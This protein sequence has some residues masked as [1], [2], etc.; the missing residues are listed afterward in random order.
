MLF[1][2]PMVRAILDGKKTMTRRI[3][4]RKLIPMIDHFVLKGEPPMSGVVS[5]YGD[6]IWVKETFMPLQHGFAYRAHANDTAI[7]KWKPS[8]FMPRVASRIT[9]EV[10]EV[11]IERL[12][13]MSREDA[14]A[15]GVDLSEELYPNVN[16][17]DKAL[18]RFPKLWDSINA[19]RGF[20]WETNPWV[21]VI[22]FRVVK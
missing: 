9:L 10:G 11:R 6:R 13:Q 12:H 22:P 1:S 20:A 16:A 15:E 3:V 18:D 2:G 5:P 8:I 4:K 17:A 14:L 19:R 21:W 7:G